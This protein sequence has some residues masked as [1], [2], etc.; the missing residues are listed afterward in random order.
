MWCQQ[1]MAGDQTHDALVL[2]ISLLCPSL[3]DTPYACLWQHVWCH[4]CIP[5]DQT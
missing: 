5:G 3:W 2:C 1:C 4:Q